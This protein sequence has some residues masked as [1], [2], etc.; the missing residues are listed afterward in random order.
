MKREGAKKGGS[1][2]GERGRERA[3]RASVGEKGLQAERGRQCREL[4]GR[5]ACVGFVKRGAGEVRG[6]QGP[7]SKDTGGGSAGASP[8]RAVFPGASPGSAPEPPDFQ[9]RS[10][11]RGG[12]GTHFLTRPG[13]PS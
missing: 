4:N 1:S 6:A 9:G 3:A 10:P 5:S 2:I 12:P 7:G 8:R 13:H 11:R